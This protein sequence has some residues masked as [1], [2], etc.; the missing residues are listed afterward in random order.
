ME[1][2]A[3]GGDSEREIENSQ[4]VVV[5]MEDDDIVFLFLLANTEEEGDKLSCKSGV[6][7]WASTGDGRR[8]MKDASSGGA[9]EALV[10]STTCFEFCGSSGWPSSM[11]TGSDDLVVILELLPG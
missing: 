8:L 1:T 2:A 3:A 6:A 4:L 7:S 5:S 10:G 9:A 11:T